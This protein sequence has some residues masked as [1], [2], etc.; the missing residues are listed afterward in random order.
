MANGHAETNSISHRC[1]SAPHI[2]TT[3]SGGPVLLVQ[4]VSD[5]GPNGGS[6]PFAPLVSDIR[7]SALEFGD[8]CEYPSALVLFLHLRQIYRDSPIP[9]MPASIGSVIRMHRQTVLTALDYLLA[10]GLVSQVAGQR[11]AGGSKPGRVPIPA[12]YTI[13]PL[14]EET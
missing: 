1:T 10:K 4:G 13:Q 12:I 5:A 3:G 9:I 14:P 7:L 6:E 11:N 8:L 2:L